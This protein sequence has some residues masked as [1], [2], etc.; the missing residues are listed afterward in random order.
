M[1]NKRHSPFSLSNKR[2]QNMCSAGIAIFYP[3]FN[4]PASNYGD[5]TGIWCNKVINILL[6]VTPEYNVLNFN[7]SLREFP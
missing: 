7:Y 6:D 3:P 4:L 2:L 5:K 1:F